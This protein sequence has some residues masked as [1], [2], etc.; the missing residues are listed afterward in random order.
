MCL[1]LWIL[2][3]LLGVRVGE[4]SNP[5]PSHLDDPEGD[6]WAAM[7]REEDKWQE[8]DRIQLGL[9]E[10]WTEWADACVAEGHI[11]TGISGGGVADSAGCKSDSV[12]TRCG[13]VAGRPH[14]HPS[15]SALSA[16][17]LNR[18]QWAESLALRDAP[19]HLKRHAI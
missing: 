3:G 18:W 1:L 14:L 12:S 15:D 17:Q 10:P 7:L 2:A 16:T 9:E 4:A 5:G 8:A 6:G 11:G 13:G 19:L